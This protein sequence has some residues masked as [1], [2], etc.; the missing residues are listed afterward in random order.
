MRDKKLS[1]YIK[2]HYYT[3][4]KNF[5]FTIFM[6]FLIENILKPYLDNLSFHV[7]LNESSTSPGVNQMSITLLKLS[8][9]LQKA[10]ALVSFCG[11]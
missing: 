2:I 8:D 11:L 4:G 9:T 1:A 3:G 7:I 6:P 10:E 5:F